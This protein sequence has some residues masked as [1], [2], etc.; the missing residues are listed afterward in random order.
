MKPLW[1]IKIGGNVIDNP[2]ALDIF[3]KDF[4]ALDGAKVLIHGGGK[5]A[6]QIAKGLG[7]ETQMVNGRRITDAEMLKIVTMVYGGLVNKNLVAKLQANGTNAI[8]MTGAD[9]NVI[10]AVKRPVK[11]VDF[12]FVGD[13]T[14]TSINDY[15][16][17]QIL[18]AGLVPVFAALTHDGKGQML[19][20]NADTIASALAVGLS[21]RY[22]TKLIYCF[23]KNGVLT[24]INDDNSVIAK[25]NPHYF[26]ELTQQGVIADGMLPKLQNAFD[27]IANGVKEVY[28]GNA[29]KLSDI[30]QGKDFGTCLHQN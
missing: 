24:D 5:I 7:V 17:A 30:N 3:L 15:T 28:I 25:I 4:S 19:N 21:S 18:E 16:L 29:A 22:E 11:E 14:E 26:E 20:T 9:G 12:G 27:A 6:T 13:L 1:I 8:G 10:Q 2:D 23:E